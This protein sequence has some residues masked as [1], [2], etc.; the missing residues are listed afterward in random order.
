MNT[1]K[2]AVKNNTIEENDSDDEDTPSKVKGKKEKK[3]DLK[4]DLKNDLKK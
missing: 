1:M 2:I 3:D 4:N